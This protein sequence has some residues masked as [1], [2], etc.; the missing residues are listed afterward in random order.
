[1][2]S[3]EGRV[4]V[5]TG[6]G[7]GMGRAHACLLASR[8]ASVVVQDILEAEAR[9]TVRMV[10]D[11]GAEAQAIVCDV[12]DIRSLRA[13]LAAMERRLGRLD[14]LVNNAGIGGEAPLDEISEQEF[15]RMFAVHVK[16][17]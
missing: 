12:T 1:M 8:G 11:G 10:K 15:D 5:I 17:S 9:E 6:A 3:F 2:S 16:G 13:E 4:A 14:I 7:R